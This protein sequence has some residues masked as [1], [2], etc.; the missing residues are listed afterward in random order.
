MADAGSAGGDEVRRLPEQLG[1]LRA[2]DLVMDGRGV[3]PAAGPADHALVTVAGEHGL[4]SRCQRAVEYRRSL[5]PSRP[6]V[7]SGAV[8]NAAVALDLGGLEIA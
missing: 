7:A 4:T 6:T 8:Q 2:Q 3:A 5:I 1:L